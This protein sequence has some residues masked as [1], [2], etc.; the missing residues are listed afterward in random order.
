[1]AKAD[2]TCPDSM[3]REINEDHIRDLEKKIEEG[4]GDVIQLKRARNSLLNVSTRIPPEILGHIFCL[5]IFRRGRHYNLSEPHKGSYNFLL[6]C[7]HWFE[8]ASHT[9]EL[10][11]YWG[12]TLK[13]WSK[14]S[15]R[16]GASP[17]DLVLG[18]RQFNRFYTVRHSYATLDGPLRDILRE[19]AEC[20]AIRSIHLR[21]GRGS[22]ITSVLSAIT[23]NGEELRCSSIE[24]ISLREVDSSNFFARHRFPKLRYL[25]LSVGPRIPPWE[26]L[27]L[28]TS[29]LTTLSIIIKDGTSNPTAAQLLSILTS[30]PRLQYLNLS[31][32]AIS[33]D[34]GGAFATP[35]P[36]RHL[37]DLSIDGNFRSVFRLLHRL[38]HPERMTETTLAVRSCIVEDIARTFWPYVRNHIERDGRFRD[39][40]GIFLHSFPNSV[41]I[42]ASAIEG[43]EGVA[44]RVTFATFTAVHQGDIP[45]HDEGRL[46]TDFLAHIPVEHVVYFGGDIS[47]DVIRRTVPAMP[48]IRELHLTNAQLV[49]RFLQPDPKEPL[50]ENKLLSSLQRLH[51]E[52]VILEDDESWDPLLPYLV[53]QASNGQRISLTISGGRGHVCK[54]VVKEME[55]LVEEFI[56]DFVESDNC[57][58]DYCGSSEGEEEEDERSGSPG[59]EEDPTA[60]R[61]GL[62]T[63]HCKLVAG[64]SN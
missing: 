33:H 52:D 22:L 34:C 56:L 7:H 48:N 28:H 8:V 1:M 37:E 57:P 4:A 63:L 53:H 50:A 39:G 19:R 36:L 44:R 46:C 59:G 12:N 2:T 38:G 14:R 58:F 25:R 35:V 61:H 13:Q 40:L 55:G 42:Q 60:V 62:R 51:L 54:S 16:S 29:A 20:D 49:D 32:L 30:N 47:M 24:S 23:S 17:V 5:R 45:D 10:W 9:P 41:S 43:D 18:G 3:G 6:V 21:G 64:P 11:S 27:A 31:G 26:H 15:K